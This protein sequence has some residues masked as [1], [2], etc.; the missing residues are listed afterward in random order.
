MHD[1]Y[2][3]FGQFTKSKTGKGY[4]SHY[5]LRSVR[6]HGGFEAV[7]R[8]LTRPQAQEGFDRMPELLLMPP[9]LLPEPWASPLF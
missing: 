3:V 6:K 4:W 5:Q 9:E 1:S 2:W 8:Y 7:K